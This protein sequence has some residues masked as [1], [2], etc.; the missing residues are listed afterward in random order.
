M[1]YWYEDTPEALR[2]KLDIARIMTFMLTGVFSREIIVAF[3]H[4]WNIIRGRKCCGVTGASLYFLCR[5]ITT[6]ALGMGVTSVAYNVTGMS[7]EAMTII[8]HIRQGLIFM[9]NV[10]AYQIFVIRVTAIWRHQV[11]GW[12][13][14]GAMLVLWVLNL[15][16]E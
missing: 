14:Y 3:H 11:V 16:G 9:A 12:S 6:A 15:Y 13:L 8:V 5:H 2:K 7:S 4:D 1:S 10:L